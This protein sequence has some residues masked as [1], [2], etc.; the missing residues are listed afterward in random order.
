MENLYA[1]ITADTN[2]GDIIAE[3]TGITTEDAEKLSSAVDRLKTRI[4]NLVANFSWG[5]GDMKEESND[6]E[7]IYPE[8][9]GE[10]LDLIGNLTPFGDYGIHTIESIEIFTLVKKIL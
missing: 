3:R 7:V 4:P 10:E 6:P 1:V 5:T 9:T 8:L 2:D